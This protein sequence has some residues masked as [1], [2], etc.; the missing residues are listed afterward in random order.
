[1]LEPNANPAD[2]STTDTSTVGALLKRARES[3]QL[4]RQQVAEQLN[5]LLS[6]VVALEENDFGRFPGETFVRG[7]L[8]SYARLLHIDANELLRLYGGAATPRAT[9][10]QSSLKWRPVSLE[11][12]ASH[13]R[14]YSGLAATMLV[15][16]VLWGWQQ[17]RDQTQRL[18]LTA[19]NGE[20][21]ELAG[22]IESALSSGSENAL[23]DSVQLL[24]NPAVKSEAAP[25]A[26]TVADAASAPAPAAEA[27]DQLSLLFSA[28]CWIE[29]KDRDNKLIVATLKRANEKL[30][31]EGRGPF[32]VLLGYA[33]GVSMA[34]NGTPVKVDVTDGRRSTRLIVGSS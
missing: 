27:I 17:H 18:S 13:W 33:P 1:M 14:R 15:L 3:K 2:Q 21:Q 9:H 10:M 7:H 23:L 28:D 4:S 20:T 6:Q 19:D 24:P 31:I 29:I 8:R 34:Y 26:N 5:L 12:K 11:R 32:K 22:G 25:A 30:Q 16:A